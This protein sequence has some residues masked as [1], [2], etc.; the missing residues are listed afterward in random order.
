[1]LG[2]VAWWISARPNT[3]SLPHFR[4]SHSPKNPDDAQARL[5][6][7]Q[8]R[9][10]NPRTST[11][12]ANIRARELAH[13]Q[14]LAARAPK[15]AAMYDT[16]WTPRGPY[17]VGGRTRALVAFEEDGDLVL[18]A[19]GVSGGVF[20]SEDGGTSW[21]LTTSLADFA[22][23][24]TIAQDPS[25]PDVFYYGTGEAV[26][27]SASTGDAFY[28]GEGIYKSINAGRSWAPLTSTTLGHRD[29]FDQLFDIIWKIA[30]DENGV[31]YA[32]TLGGIMRSD[33]GGQSWDQIHGRSEAPFSLF[34]DVAIGPNNAV[35]ATLSRNGTGLTPYGVFRLQDD[36]DGW[37]DITPNQLAVNPYR[38]V[39]APAPSDSNTVYLLAQVTPGGGSTGEHQLL[40]Y[41]VEDDDWN[42]QTNDLPLANGHPL[43]GLNSQTGYNLTIG[44]KP[45]DAEILWIGGTNL[46]LST[47]G[48]DSFDWV[49][50]YDPDP[51]GFVYPNHHPDQHALAFDPDD[52]NT[53]FSAHDGGVSVTT[54]AMEEQTIWTSLNNG[55]TSTQFYT[56]AIPP[57]G[58][59]N[60]MMGGMQD[61]GTWMTNTFTFETP[62]AEVLTGDG[63]YA[64][65]SPNDGPLY[66]SAQLGRVFRARPVGNE[67]VYAEVTP[68]NASDFLFI[69]PFTL[70]PADPEV[71]YLAAGPLV[72][73]NSDLSAIPDN[74]FD[75]TTTNWEA[76][77]RA[78][79]PNLVVTA[80]AAST[81][82]S[83]RLY[84]G[85][86]NFFNDT[87]LIRVDDPANNG[88]GLDITPPGVIGGSYPS[89]IAVNPDDT[90]EIIATFSNYD[91]P[92][93]FYSFD[94]G[95]TWTNI[96]GNLAGTNGPSVRW[97]TIVP[98]GFETVYFVGT[99]TGIYSTTVPDGAG[100]KANATWTPEAPGVIGNLV[101]DMMQGRPD[102]GF[103]A[104]GS[105]G[106]GAYS[107]R[108]STTAR[109]QPEAALSTDTLHIELGT[110]D[111][112]SALFTL[113][114]TG[115]A[116]LSYS[117]R[118]DDTRD[119]VTIDP[120]DGRILPGDNLDV[121]VTFDAT[122]LNIGTYDSAVI[123]ATNDSTFT[124]PVRAEV[125]AAIAEVNVSRLEIAQYIDETNTA[126]FEISNSG[127]V[128]L[129][130]QL[131]VETD[132]ED[133]DETFL[134]T[135]SAGMVAPNATQE[136][137]LAFSATAVTDGSYAAEVRLTGN[138]GDINIPVELTVLPSLTST[139]TALEIMVR[140]D[141]VNST[142]FV[143][144]N[145]SAVPITFLSVLRES[146]G[147]VTILP[148]SGTIPPASTQTITL[149]FDA[150]GFATGS[151]AAELFVSSSGGRLTL[152][153]SLVVLSGV[154]TEAGDL[155]TELWL[156]DNYPNPF[157]PSTTIAFGLPHATEVTLEVFDATGRYVMTLIDGLHPAGNHTVSW[158]GHSSVGVPVPSGLY[159]YRLRTHAAANHRAQTRTG[160]MLLVK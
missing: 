50:G 116:P 38:M 146:P 148:L 93:I 95:R 100:L 5:A 150:T 117:L 115:A 91:V 139:T 121:T 18:L 60:T 42:D 39:L 51:D 29:Q 46:F 81:R 17:N 144:E 74:S 53:L 125:I 105:H 143:L 97:A 69:T 119:A 104:A 160:H 6:Y 96:E 99:T 141:E 62:W 98:T 120:L 92:S 2:G 106:R 24:T 58:T 134:L 11:V 10:R 15:T 59:G 14:Q 7:E 78:S 30:V 145:L 75:P 61:N 80:L 89:S 57:D 149:R 65:F 27:N 132:L 44:V 152:P 32:A 157:N 48:G 1:M 3:P 79:V 153:L 33:D 130:Y 136:V 68:A 103:V 13:A 142:S 94:G 83:G 28:F 64:A 109:P 156:G 45:D 35:Y 54:D 36:G 73:R 4:S 72:W 66:V 37:D 85:T 76:L 47:D 55:Y 31:V 71:M 131:A 107:A 129:V 137:T 111:M 90:N 67:L 147:G 12:P 87:R 133:A 140:A 88:D 34:T 118:V 49:G 52:P 82:P 9:I 112:E 84:F 63:A 158:N 21:T 8:L 108:L 155:P 23:V 56:I 70:D 41:D 16:P 127:S 110:D 40:R 22:N 151:Y 123:V 86:S 102:D 124:V 128:D 122:G 159:L 114:N 135:P 20:R 126:T 138:G 26:G 19:G 77:F 154:G 25:D 101:I 113:G 43:G